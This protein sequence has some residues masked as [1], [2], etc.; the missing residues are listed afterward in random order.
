[1]VSTSFCFGLTHS[2]AI[3]WR[4]IQKTTRRHLSTHWSGT[5]MTNLKEETHP[6]PAWNL[7]TSIASAELLYYIP[8]CQG[9]YFQ[10]FSCHHNPLAKAGS[11]PASREKISAFTSDSTQQTLLG[12]KQVTSGSEVNS[13]APNSEKMVARALGLLPKKM[14]SLDRCMGWNTSLHCTSVT[15]AGTVNFI[16][17]R[18]S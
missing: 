1:M 11:P 6:C 16:V 12:I 18:L 15:L 13:K 10:V 8:G 7:P 9:I 5:R 3:A 2:I 4:P 17:V 14:L